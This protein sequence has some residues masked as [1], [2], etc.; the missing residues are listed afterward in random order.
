MCIVSVERLFFCTIKLLL[1]AAIL[2]LTSFLINLFIYIIKEKTKNKE[3]NKRFWLIS[4]LIRFLIEYS[5][6]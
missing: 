1:K 2:D 6:S 3:L 4:A 5:L